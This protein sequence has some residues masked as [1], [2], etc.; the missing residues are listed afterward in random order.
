MAQITR[1]EPFRVAFFDNLSQ[2]EQVVRDL[3]A[4][5]YT[6]RQLAVIV[7][8]RYRDQFTPDVPR[9]ERPAGHAAE[10]IL[11]GG[12]IGAALGGV[13]LVAATLATGGAALLPAIPVLVG[14]G[15]I[16]GAFSG[17]ITRDGYWKGVGEYY[18]EAIHYGKIVVGVEIQDEDNLVR[19]EQ[20]RHILEKAG[21]ILARPEGR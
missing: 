20:A 7:P 15:A 16:A 8:D 19:L 2:A 6:K 3:L 9:A 11:E 4:A 17:L 14:G 13:A 5:G 18:D 12:A 1:N 21:G 10:T